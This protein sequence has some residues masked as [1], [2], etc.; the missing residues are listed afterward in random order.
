MEGSLSKIVAIIVACVI[1]FIYPIMTMF[2]RQDDTSRVFVL[3]ETTKFVD[4]VRN[5]GYISPNMYQEFVNKLLA[6]NNIYDIQ[7][8]HR[9]RKIDPV[10]GDPTNVASF[11]DDIGVNFSAFYTDDIMK[12][13]FPNSHSSNNKYTF[14]KGDYFMVRVVNKN[15]TV[16]TKIKEMLYNADFDNAQIYIAYGGM[17]KNENY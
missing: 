2:E 13:L 16:A 11:K 17:V 10:Y 14:S 3:S 4:S 8:E 1:F 5:L 12:V 7:M 6:T 9:H 15:K